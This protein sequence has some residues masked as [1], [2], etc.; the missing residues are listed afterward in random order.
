[1]AARRAKQVKGSASVKGGGKATGKAA[2]KATPK[3]K[4]KAKPT[5]KAKPKAGRTAAAARDVLPTEWS[6]LVPLIEHSL[7]ALKRDQFLVLACTGVNRFVQFASGGP[8]RLLGEV[9]SDHFLDVDE[10]LTPAEKRAI[11]ALGWQPPTHADDAPPRDQVKGGSPNWFRDFSGPGA[12]VRAAEAAAAT[13]WGAFRHLPAEVR[14]HA[15][16]KDGEELTL[17]LGGIAPEA[18]WMSPGFRPDDLDDLRTMVLDTLT[19]TAL[20]QTREADGVDL[21]V[22]IGSRAVFVTGHDDPMSVLLYTVVGEMSEAPELL[23]TLNGLNRSRNGCRALLYEGHLIVDRVLPGDP[24]VP[25]Q[26]VEAVVELAAW[27]NSIEHQGTEP[28]M[29]PVLN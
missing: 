11:A 20:G 7:R 1:M 22:D 27:A 17:P 9:V 26:L 10:R 25:R 28:T 12:A 23:E 13:L 2:R 3:A 19:G 21:V 8:S 16:A 29:D 5:V 15:F 6:L 4:A 14:Y 18:E 24:F